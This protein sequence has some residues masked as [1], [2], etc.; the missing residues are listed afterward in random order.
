MRLVKP[1]IKFMWVTQ[2]PL[3]Q[4]ELAGRTCYKSEKGISI[5][6]AKLFV[7][8]LLDRGHE[9]MIEHASAS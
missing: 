3:L 2:E 9:A 8:E 7:K 6:S 1:S 5:G 4:I